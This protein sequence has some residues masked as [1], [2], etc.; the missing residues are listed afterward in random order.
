MIRIGDAFFAGN[1]EWEIDFF[2]GEDGSIIELE[3]SDFGCNEIKIY[4]QKNDIM[5]STAHKSIYFDGEFFDAELNIE[6]MIM[7]IEIIGELNAK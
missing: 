1:E 2:D 3:N 7:C 6:E 4:V 5:Q